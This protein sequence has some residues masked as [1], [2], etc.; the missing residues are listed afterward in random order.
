MNNYN[1]D[2][3]KLLGIEDENIKILGVEDVTTPS[4]ENSPLPPKVLFNIVYAKLEYKK[5]YCTNCGV[6]CKNSV[7]KNGCKSSCIPLQ[8]SGGTDVYLHLKKQRYMCRNC[9]K[10]TTAK[11]N[12]VEENCYISLNLKREVIY[13]LTLETSRKAIAI[14]CG[15]SDM[16]VY[17][18]QKSLYKFQTKNPSKKL[19]EYLCFDEFRSTNDVEGK[20]SFIY[21]DALNHKVIDILENH[22]TNT[23][24]NI[25]LIDMISKID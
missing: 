7:I 23:I 3:K 8:K 12:I 11:T 24:K 25:S 2:I 21:C 4:C 5:P 17:N 20:L 15:I 6:K 9:Q 18:I 14:E 10:H 13:R 19:P 22:R 1:I 16:T